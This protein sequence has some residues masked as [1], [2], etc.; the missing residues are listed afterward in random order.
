MIISLNI[1]SENIYYKIYE[2]IEL[3]PLNLKLKL[4]YKIKQNIIFI[5]YYTVL[6]SH[7]S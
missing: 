6:K 4:E 2:T 3:C 5:D 7:S 1:D